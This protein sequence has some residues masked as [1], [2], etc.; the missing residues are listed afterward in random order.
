MAQRVLVTRF[1]IDVADEDRRSIGG[2][3][4][5]DLP[6]DPGR[7]RSL[8]VLAGEITSLK[9][10]ICDVSKRADIE[11]MV[12][13]CAQALGGLDVLV[14]NAG[15]SGPTAPVEN[16]DPDKWERVMQVDL[17]GTF[18]RYA[19]GYS[20]PEEVSSRRY[21]QHVFC[22]RAFRVRQPEPLLHREVG[23]DRFH[24]DSFY[25]AG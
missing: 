17:T 25:R 8:N 6:S 19:A 22:G 24:Q 21:H 16:M 3:C 13:E 1:C 2:K 4:S 18:Q 20:P 12:A 23:D 15:I 11:H 5:D 10:G 9:I 14:N 7:S